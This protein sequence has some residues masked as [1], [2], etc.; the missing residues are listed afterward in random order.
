MTVDERTH[1]LRRTLR[2]AARVCFSLALTALASCGGSFNN[3]PDV[4]NSSTTG[5]RT[6]AFAYFQRCINPIFFTPVGSNTCSASGCHDNVNGTGG[7]L[8][9]FAS[10]Q[11][12]DVLN[13]A[14]TPDV[15]RQSDMYKNFVSASSVVIVGSPGDSRL[16]N[17]PLVRGILHGGGQIFASDQD[18]AIKRMEYW[19]THPSTQGDEFSPS[20]YGMFDNGNPN[21]GGC[22]S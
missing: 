13:A 19:I 4:V 6:L 14:N 20:T 12:I 7:A 1:Q 11:V 18:P 15:I 5:N 21:T 17:K 3:P 10:A 9:V 22:N 2:T 16:I 8:R